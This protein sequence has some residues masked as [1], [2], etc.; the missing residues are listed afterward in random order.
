M[1][2]SGKCVAILN[3]ARLRLAACCLTIPKKAAVKGLQSMC[4][5][6]AEDDDGN[7]ATA[8]VPHLVGY[9]AT[10]EVHRI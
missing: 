10:S 9:D 4:G 2:T 1:E 5:V 6:P 3:N 8:S 7:A